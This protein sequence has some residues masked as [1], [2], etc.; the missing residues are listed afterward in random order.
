MFP[1]FIPGKSSIMGHL[2]LVSA[3]VVLACCIPGTLTCAKTGL[4][5]EKI[6]R[7]LNEAKQRN[8]NGTMHLQGYGRGPTSQEYP[9]AEW[10]PGT[11]IIR[12]PEGGTLVIFC[13]NSHN[14]NNTEVF[15]S[16]IPPAFRRN[17]VLIPLSDFEI[18]RRGFEEVN[19]CCN[20]TNGNNPLEYGVEGKVYDLVTSAFSIA[21]PK[22][23]YAATGL[24]ECLHSN[25]HQLVVTQ[26]YWVSATLFRNKVFDPP[27][28]NLTIRYGDPAELVCAVR[29]NF[30]PGYL[31]NRFLWRAGNYLLMA[32]SI[33]EVADKIGS[34]W[35]FYGRV[36]FGK[37]QQGRCN[38]TLKIDRVTWRDAGL[39]ECWFRINDRLDEWIVQEAYLHVI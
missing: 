3:A 4:S 7:I 28:K 36:D 14:T 37:D 30:L 10:P 27:M 5:V 34:W 1:S 26:R 32:K 13:N 8:G 25:G 2:L 22:F 31:T 39:Y 15:H 12:A 19:Y 35:G 6:N 24:Y 33:P 20:R 17:G 18:A 9:I 23:S 11:E 29:F 16:D 38:S 21:L